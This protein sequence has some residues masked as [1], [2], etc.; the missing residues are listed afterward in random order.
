MK[1]FCNVPWRVL[2][3][4]SLMA[5]LLAACGGGGGGGAAP[6]GGGLPPGDQLDTTPDAFSFAA[7]SNVGAGAWV[8]SKAITISGLEALAPIEAAGGEYK[9]NAGSYTNAPG[10]VVNGDQLTVRVQASVDAGERAMMR[11]TV[12]GF[13]AA[14][15]VTT[16]GAVLAN[17]MVPSTAY[18][19]LAALLPSLKPG[20]VVDVQP[21]PSGLPYG[22]IKFRT[23][24]TAAQPIILRGMRVAGVLPQIKGYN[25]DVGGAIKFEGAHH[26]VLDSFEITNGFNALSPNVPTQARTQALY[27][28]SNQAH[29]VQIRRSKVFDCLNHGILGNDEESGS[30]TL[31]Q[32]EVSTA[33]CDATKG[34]QCQNN[35]IKHPIYVATD[36][37]A[38]PGSVL[39]IQNSYLH[40]NIAGETI[41][42]RAQRAEIYYNWV[43]SKGQQD[44]ALGLYGYDAFDASP[45][46]PIHHD[47]VGNVLVV[48]GGP[49][50]SSMARFGGDDTGSTFGRTR[51]VNNTVLLGASFGE[52]NRSQPVIRLDG[53]LDAFI[54]HNNIFQVGG[55]PAA[56]QLVLV[57]ENNGLQWVGGT[58]KLLLTHNYMPEGSQA[59]CRKSGNICTTQGTPPNGYVLSDWVSAASPG[60]FDDITLTAPQLKLRPDSALRAANKRG[61]QDTNR[62]PLNIPS[63][64]LQAQ[65]NAPGALPGFVQAGG[66]RLDVN[67]APY[68]GAYD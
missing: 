39:R 36:P 66:A 26:M 30:L 49:D 45:S 62:A 25:T 59:L 24:G 68:L 47:V 63:A 42:S 40:S 54:A 9:I 35:A 15:E 28:V 23:P 1:N 6:P 14:F 32:V 3:L 4:V 21:L 19:T 37:E 61:T 56:R 34:M 8:A 27:C 67:S 11:V 44:H 17:K 55:N 12:G 51:F 13:S 50:S 46:N 2:G 48:E 38:H 16:Q 41:K 29:S 18:P 33:G 58:P 64:L 7:Q 60:F 31:D 53:A 22:P 10:Q 57:R 43:Q 20:D 65:K 5:A 52:A